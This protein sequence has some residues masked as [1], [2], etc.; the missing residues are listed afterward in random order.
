MRNPQA[1]KARIGQGIIIGLLVLAI[2]FHINGVD[3]FQ[4]YNVAGC[5]FFIT[6]NNLMM[7][8]MGTIGLFQQERPVFLREQANKMYDVGIYFNAKTLTELPLTMLQPLI[9]TIIIYWG[10][11]LTSSAE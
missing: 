9:T 7:A 2:F 10:I 6:V 4:R 3:R 11:G 5:F 8:L 1:S